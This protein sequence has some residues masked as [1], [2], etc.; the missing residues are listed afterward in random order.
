MVSFIASAIQ[1][2][3]MTRM[4]ETSIRFK[5]KQS[6][7]ERKV[8]MYLS[9]KASA[10]RIREAEKARNNRLEILKACVAHDGADVVV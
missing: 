2:I 3:P 8:S 9:S 10:A 6:I 1:Q 5:A 4:Q 7:F